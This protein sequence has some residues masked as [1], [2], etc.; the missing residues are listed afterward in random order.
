M[1]AIRIPLNIDT[2]TLGNFLSQ[3]RA[4]SKPVTVR[5]LVGQGIDGLHVGDVQMS[6]GSYAKPNFVSF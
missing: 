2:E 3:P 5:R 1:V 6:I 4:Y